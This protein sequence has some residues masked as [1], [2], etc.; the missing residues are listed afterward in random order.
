MRLREVAT[1]DRADL[2]TPRLLGRLRRFVRRRM[3]REHDVDDVVQD[4]LV[5]FL[6]RGALVPEE[7]VAPWL[8]AVARREIVDRWRDPRSR[9][10]SP[11][12][13][14]VSKEVG[15]DADDV[16]AD[17]SRCMT[18]MLASLPESDR[19]LLWRVDAGGATQAAV[20]RETRVKPSTVKSRVQR[21]RRRLRAALERCC[22]IDQD[23]GGR[24]VAYRRRTNRPCACG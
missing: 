21:A 20:V 14:V 3:A 15:P 23:R 22:A 16:V 8:L 13:D 4:V 7:S 6:E 5:K 11:L 19:T 10:R 1:V 24:P 2:L 17:L 18:P 9:S 12:P